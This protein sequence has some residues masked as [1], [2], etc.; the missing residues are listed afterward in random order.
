MWWLAQSINMK[1]FRLGRLQFEPIVIEEDMVGEKE[2]ILKGTRALNVHVPAGG[3]DLKACL[4][5]FRNA[6]AFFGKKV[7]YMFV[8]PGCLHQN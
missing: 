3:H 7:R 6:E 5:S 2:V 8:I 1:L 4:D